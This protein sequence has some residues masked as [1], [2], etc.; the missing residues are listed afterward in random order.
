[1]QYDKISKRVVKYG[2]FFAVGISLILMGG[3]RFAFAQ[4]SSQFESHVLTGDDLK[5]DPLAQKILSEIEYSKKHIAQIEQDQ[6]NTELNAMQ[7]Q[8][9]P[10]FNNLSPYKRH[11]DKQRD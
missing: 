5:N 4:T 6:R 9:P 3:E 10:N 1:M 7:V 2:L 8:K 11:A